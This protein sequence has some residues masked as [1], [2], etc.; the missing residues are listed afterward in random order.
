[1]LHSIKPQPNEFSLLYLSDGE[2]IINSIK[3]YSFNSSS[4]NM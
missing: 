4:K 1:M 3:C 2:C